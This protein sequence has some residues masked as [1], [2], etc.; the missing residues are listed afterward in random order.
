MAT[1]EHARGTRQARA[2]TLK[3][4]SAVTRSESELSFPIPMASSSSCIS[5]LSSPDDSDID[6]V[7]SEATDLCVLEQIAALNTAHL[8][9][10]PL[11]TDIDSR[12]KKLKSFPGSNPCPKI[13]EK[14]HLPAPTIKGE[15][16]RDPAK[17]GNDAAPEV[18][19]PSGKRQGFGSSSSISRRSPS[20]NRVICCFGG[21]RKKMAQS[22]SGEDFTELFMDFG[23]SSSLKGQRRKLEKVLREQ[24]K[25]S[26][27][28]EKMV[29]S[30]EAAV[31]RMN[32]AALDQLMD[33]DGEEEFK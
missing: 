7:I 18:S 26:R 23:A 27:E 17:P 2:V 4:E 14:Y 11:P 9:D 28:V 31:A 6:A 3:T 16:I 32:A 30:I 5:H 15:D 1:Q 8:S 22:R 13:Q 20:P 25:A 24:E 33:G 12:F 29:E 19:S 10:S 21:S